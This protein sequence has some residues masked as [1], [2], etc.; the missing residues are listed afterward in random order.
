[1][2]PLRIIL[3]AAIFFLLSALTPWII[4][5]EF[6]GEAGELWN[7]VSSFPGKIILITLALLLCYYLCDGLRLWFILRALRQHQ[8]L[9]RMAPLVFINMLFSSITPMATG[10]GLIQ[11]G[12]L[13]KHGVHLGAA[14]A[15]TTLRT[16]L[17][18]LL[19]FL[20][21]PFILLYVDQVQLGSFAH[22]W[23]SLLAAF[24]LCYT[25]FFALVI[26]RIRWLIASSTNIL[27]LF[28]RSGLIHHETLRRWHFRLRKEMIRFNYSIRAYL[29]RSPSNATWS[30]LF[31]VLFLLCLFSFPAVLLWGFGYPIDYPMVLALMTINTFVMYFAPTPGAAG[32]AEG[33]FALL[34]AS[35][36]SNADIL[37][38]VLGWRFLTVH[39]GMLIGIPVS[40]HALAAR[41]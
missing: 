8:P 32:V 29:Q 6:N 38:I 22:R 33:V 15:A 25:G 14:T 4:L 23:A 24:A 11:I 26:W 36:V 28:H 19:I 40:V 3:F 35:T 37:L 30:A 20:S 7:R 12:Y 9:K 31:T 1:M 41:R 21:A 18:S 10:G 17:A 34:F 39:L 2:K 27:T 13:H 16:L 5:R